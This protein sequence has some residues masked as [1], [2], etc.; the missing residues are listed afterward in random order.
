MFSGLRLANGWVNARDLHDIRLE[1]DLV[2]LSACET[3]LSSFEDASEQF[4][5]SRS[6][7]FAGAPSLIGS[8]WPVKDEHTF[9]LMSALYE[10]LLAGDTVASALR[11]AQITMRSEQAN[12]YF[13]ASFTVIGDPTRR[14]YLATPAPAF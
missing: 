6:F 10:R 1:A 8:L 3:G 9:R 12:P 2:V 13:W 14:P 7:L 11:S 5:L 4:G